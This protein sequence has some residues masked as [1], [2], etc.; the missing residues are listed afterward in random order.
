MK[1]PTRICIYVTEEEYARING[2]AVAEGR[3]FTGM[4]KWG[5]LQYCARRRIILKP[6]QVKPEEQIVNRF[7]LQGDDFKNL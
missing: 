3:T 5:A 2:H 6:K 7:I 1:F 4:I